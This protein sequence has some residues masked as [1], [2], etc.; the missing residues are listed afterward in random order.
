MA[1]DFGMEGRS[2]VAVRVEGERDRTVA[3]EFLNDL[4]MNAATE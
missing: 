3:E 1:G 4:G 2:D